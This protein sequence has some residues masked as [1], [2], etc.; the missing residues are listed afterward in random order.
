MTSTHA[1]EAFLPDLE[2]KQ[3]QYLSEGLIAAL[4]H[5]F[6]YKN[7]IP[8]KPQRDAAVKMSLIALVLFSIV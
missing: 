8:Y 6:L 5:Y 7:T 2:Q 3:P 1:A 4:F